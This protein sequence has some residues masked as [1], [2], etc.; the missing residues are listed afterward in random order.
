MGEVALA[1]TEEVEEFEGS[2]G[3]GGF[4]PNT[5]SDQDLEPDAEAGFDNAE[6]EETP[7]AEPEAETQE[8]PEA[9]T[10]DPTIAALQERIQ[11][12]EARLTQESASSQVLQNILAGQRQA[13]QVPTR[14][15]EQV[16]TDPN[17][18]AAAQARE[19]DQIMGQKN[20]EN[21]QILRQQINGDMAATSSEQ[22]ARGVYTEDLVGPG[23]DYDTMVQKHMASISAANPR[24]DAFIAEFGGSDPA[25]LRYSIAMLKELEDKHGT[26][27]KVWQTIL[28][29]A[30]AAASAGSEVASKIA[31]ASRKGAMKSQLKGAGGGKAT[32]AGNMSVEQINNLSDEEVLALQNKFLNA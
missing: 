12:A 22:T 29:P 7:E 20:A 28:K 27:A 13:A 25:G 31:A 15:I 18:D 21:L 17:L 5:W 10:P 9:A 26:M 3:E 14:T 2:G 19:I 1:E 8:E 30:A 16:L 23:M 4:D 32:P 24:V 6:T 11:A